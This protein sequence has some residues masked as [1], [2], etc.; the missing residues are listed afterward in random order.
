MLN[1]LAN[2]VTGDKNPYGLLLQQ[3]LQRLQKMPDAYLFHEYL[4]ECNEALYFHEF[5][6]RLTRRKLRYL[7]EADIR[8]MGTFRFPQEVR[9]AL[10]SLATNQIEMEQYLDFL[11]NR[12]FRRTL[13]CHGHQEPNYQLRPEQLAE[14]HLASCLK[15][16]NAVPDLGE[17]ACEVFVGPN[18]TSLETVEPIFKAALWCLGQNWP[19]AVGFEDLYRNASALVPSVGDAGRSAL[20]VAVLRVVTQSSWMV[21]LWQSPP[22]FV[23]EVS[24]RPTASP[25]ARWQAGRQAKVTNLRHL[26]MPISDFDRL[27]LSLLDGTRDRATL[28]GC[29]LDAVHQGRLKVPGESLEALVNQRLA[30]FAQT[31]LLVS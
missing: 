1:F 26:L 15:P 20:G 12:G 8:D 6:R 29:L 24:T 17:N 13:I 2:S 14:F 27:L 25:L 11:V 28:L 4:E 7:G 9:Q 23:I 3:S 22:R 31:A 18:E 16:R 5:C 30:E 21:E 19:R 10:G